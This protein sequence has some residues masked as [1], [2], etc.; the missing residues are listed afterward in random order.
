LQPPLCRHTLTP[1]TH[2]RESFPLPSLLAH[3]ARGLL[4]AAAL[5]AASPAPVG[6]A[7]LAGAY[8]AGMQA[9]ARNDYAEAARYYGEAL[10]RDPENLT[11]AQNAAVA[12]V[13]LGDID[14]AAVLADRLASA[15]P[16]SP[17]AVLVQLADALAAGEY[18]LAEAVSGRAGPDANPLLTGLVA[19][20]IE[21]GRDDF[22]AAQ[23]R[24]DAMTAN[25]ALAA[26]G[27]YHKA[28]ALALA[29]D[30]IGAEAILA[31]GEGGEPLHLSRAALI[32]HAQ[33]LAQIDR[34]DEAVALLDETLASG[35]PDVTLIDL[36]DRLAA[37]EEV[38][39]TQ[40]TRAQDGA[41]E[42]YLTLAEA[43]NA[44]DSDR[45]ALLYARL[46]SHIRPDLIEA[47]LLA[48]E[49]LERQGQ[50]AL[51]TA[52]LNDV[53]PDSPWFVTA[54][55]RR[56]T[57]QR[58]AGDE[59]A[60]L[61]TLAALAERRP[62]LIE[63]HSAHGDALRVAERYEEAAAA[64]TRAIDLIGTPQPLHWILYYTRAISYE[65]AG[66]WPPAEADFRQALELEPDQPMVLNYLGYS[67]VEQRRNLEEALDM[68]ERAV[69]GQPDD[70]YITDSLGWVYYRL[71]R[72]EEALPQMLR[73]V[74]LAPV[75]PVINDHLGDVLWKVGRK[76][77]AAFQWRRA[78]SFG[79]A[80]DLDMDRVRRK[81]EVGL[82]VV[83]EEEAAETDG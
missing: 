54:E 69:A 61:A 56:A 44:P 2:A 33:I 64:Y 27:Q 15:I 14:A 29:G 21:A 41:A 81:L 8:L 31:G 22:A 35:F 28:L 71:G 78:L 66:N 65:R 49:V 4:I 72:Y 77:E 50:Y 37:G 9:D 75:D 43:L 76:R 57:T 55:I 17:I 70:G 10:S 68:I 11:I 73:A 63:V 53:P 51:A 6:A 12:R 42:A 83:L 46:A 82:D 7:S 52:A 26:Y 5:A 60:G 38:A 3:A 18:D 23:A 39:F 13:A 40:V 1:E 62:D 58:A 25:E 47:R 20:W 36:R 19:G 24:F 16:G 30:F 79:P 48:A 74:E 80:D 34:V 32:A 59:E 67:L 45:L